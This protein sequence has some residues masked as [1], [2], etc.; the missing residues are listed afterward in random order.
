MAVEYLHCCDR[1][2]DLDYHVDDVVYYEYQ[3]YCYE[4]L[5][6]HIA[7]DQDITLEEAELI[8]EDLI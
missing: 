2:V 4:H 3:A 8:V 1:Y 6:E 5:V 7:N